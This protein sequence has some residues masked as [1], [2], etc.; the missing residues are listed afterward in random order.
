MA[1]QVVISGGGIGGL[2]TALA[3]AR[4]GR[5]VELLEQTEALGEVG[6]GLQLGPNA[7]RV[8]DSWGL[9]PALRACAAFPEAL[10]V[11]DV[12]SAR[13][14]G[15]LGLGD[16]AVARYGQPYATVHRADL[17]GLLL[18]AV[19]GEA[20][21]TLRLGRRVASYKE[22]ADGLRVTCEGGETVEG[23]ALIGCDGLWSRVRS[24]LLGAHPVRA[25]GH[26][27]YRG[28][29][30][31]SDL[32]AALRRSVVTA[33][34]GPRLHAVHY[35]VRQGEWINVIVVV[36]GVIGRGHGGAV[37]SDPQS[38]S[39]EAHAADLRRTLGGACSDLL[40]MVDE[41][42]SWKLWPLNDRPPMAGAHEHASGRVALVGDAA[43]PL[44]PYLA[45][46]AAMAI[47]DAWTLGQLALTPADP[48]EPIDWAVQFQRYAHTRWARNARVQARSERNGVVFHAEGPLRWARNL[49]MAALGETLMDN[50][51]LYQG[52]PAPAPEGA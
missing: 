14:L 16:R 37:G 40:A 6:A 43:H 28:M 12:H 49:A 36:Q 24:Q 15:R 31:A 47:E 52:P 42:S 4:T 21:V 5:R 20:S 3:L 7:V 1:Q 35:P 11:R 22:A 25:S 30:R 44:R 38:W 19:Q 39:H 13:N 41:V 46:G 27:A 8:L 9:L 51:W 18:Q 32:P 29:V 17:H 50:P 10:L 34:L 33:W 26:L 23:A 48:G 2:A 45:Q